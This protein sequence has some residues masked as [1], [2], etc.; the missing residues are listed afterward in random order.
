MLERALFVNG[1]CGSGKTTIAAAAADLVARTGDAVAFVDMDALS[2]SWPRPA[3][4][5]FN[6]AL[7]LRNL[8]AVV[9]NFTKAGVTSV[10]VAGVIGDEADLARYEVALGLPPAVVRLLA[11]LELIDERL[12]YRY[13]ESDSEGLAWHR[14][15]APELNDILD[16][17]TIEMATVS[18]TAPVP[19]VARTVLAACDWLPALQ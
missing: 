19:E 9:R 14:Q 12:Q 18:N 11:P 6:K 10:V 17:S 16:A 3:D 4:D 2:Q 8:E 13:G 1:T 5:P 15:R 7:G